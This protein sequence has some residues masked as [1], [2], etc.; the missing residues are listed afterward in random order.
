MRLQFKRVQTLFPDGALFFCLKVLWI[1]QVRS[2]AGG[3]VSQEI[4]KDRALDVRID[5]DKD[6]SEIDQEESSSANLLLLGASARKLIFSLRRT[7][8]RRPEQ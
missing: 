7:S 5:S 8:S 6:G 3:R 1:L 4:E 2:I